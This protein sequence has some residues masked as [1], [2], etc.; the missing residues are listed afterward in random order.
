MLQIDQATIDA[1]AARDARGEETAFIH[2]MRSK[3][4]MSGVAEEQLRA[5]WR[6][7]V[8]DSAELGIDDDQRH[9]ISLHAAATAMMGEMTAEQFLK[10]VDILFLNEPRE[11]RLDRIVEV[12]RTTAGRRGG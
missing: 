4:A 5:L 8:A 10:M 6:G 11:Q 1:F 3:P 12:A 7:A 9:Q 2:W